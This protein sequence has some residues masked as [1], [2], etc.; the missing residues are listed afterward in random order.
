MPAK[1]KS[2]SSSA[3]S[4]TTTDHE[5]IRKWAEE[6][7]GKPS[8]VLG[9]GGSG[10]AG[11]LRI[12]FPGYSGEGKLKPISWDE[13]FEK[14]DEENL[15]LLYQ[16]KTKDGEPSNFN[17]LVNRDKSGDGEKQSA[18]RHGRGSR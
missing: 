9:T 3:S 17:K 18:G 1:R 16:E 12:D 2:S 14:F 8:C 11:V 15:A 4:K 5:Q 6:R 10:D 13:F 7:G